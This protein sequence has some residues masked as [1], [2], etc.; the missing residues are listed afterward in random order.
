MVLQKIISGLG[1]K[2]WQFHF[3]CPIQLWINSDYRGDMLL[4]L[5]GFEN[6]IPYEFDDN[7]EHYRVSTLM[8]ILYLIHFTVA[9]FLSRN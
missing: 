1:D 5:L 9:I 8:P 7:G 3:Q 4:I 6:T 2:T